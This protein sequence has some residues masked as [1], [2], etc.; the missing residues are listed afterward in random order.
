[1]RRHFFIARMAGE[2]PIVENCRRCQKAHVPLGGH[3]IRIPGLHGVG[4]T[5]LVDSG[6][7]QKEEAPS[8]VVSAGHALRMLLERC[9][10]DIVK[11]GMQPL[12]EVLPLTWVTAC[13]S[14][15]TGPG[16]Q[17]RTI[18][19]HPHPATGVGKTGPSVVLA[20]VVCWVGTCWVEMVLGS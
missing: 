17:P 16:H 1:M 15:Y 7:V 5:R 2:C 10:A 12:L 19:P 6:I 13:S 8:S 3:T 9:A 20:T 4:G 14:P 11:D 18:K